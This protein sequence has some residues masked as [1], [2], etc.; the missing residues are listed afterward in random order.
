MRAIGLMSG[1]SLDGMDA[2]LIET[3][4]E[5]VTCFGPALT[6]PFDAPT[7]AALQTAVADALQWRFIGPTPASF[8]PAAKKLAISAK[9]AVLAIV[10]QAQLDLGDIDV[11]G[12][13]GQTVVHLPPAGESLGQTCQ[14][15]DAKWLAD[16]LKTQIVHDFRSKDMHAGGHGAPL[17]PGYHVALAAAQPKPFMVLNLG[18]VG[19][20]TWIGEKGE[21]LAFDTGPANGPIDAWINANGVGAYDQNGA[22]AAKGHIDE[23]RLA[24]LLAAPYFALQPPKSAD[25]WDFDNALIEGL[26]VEDGAATLTAWCARS[27]QKALNFLPNPPL[28]IAVCGGGRKNPILMALLR[29]YTKLDVVPVED[30]GWR[31]DALE[32]EAFAFL[33]VRRLRQLPTSWPQTTGINRPACGGE[34]IQP[35]SPV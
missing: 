31:G 2:A 35:E 25:R 34:V 30:L 5:C 3:D 9:Q 24:T 7:K 1:T 20:L 29:A 23:K 6:L 13:H 17:A 11:V 12:F 15:G 33:A 21:I 16:S 10:Q 22:L 28:R 8:V 4:G 19:N 18:G 32:A 26:G 27:V 14:I